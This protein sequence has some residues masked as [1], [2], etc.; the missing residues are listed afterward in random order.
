MNKNISELQIYLFKEGTN[1]ESYKMLG[2][3]LTREGCYFAVWAPNAR[4]VSV[5]GDFN[6]WNDQIHSMDNSESSGIWE[7]FIEGVREGAVYK[8]CIEASNGDKVLKSDPFG[9]SAETRP[10]N[11]S[12]VA[13]IDGYEW[14]DSQWEGC[15]LKESPQCK[16]MSIYEVNLGSWR[17]KEDG[18][19]LSYCELADELIAYVKDMKYTHIEIM[20]IS[21]YPFDGSWGYQVTGYFGVTSRYGSP[22][23]FMYMVDCC[24]QNNIGVILD[25]VPAHFPKDAHGLARFDG[26]CLYEHEDPRRG[27]HQDWGTYVFNF[28]RNEVRSFLISSAMF[29]ADCCH[30]DGIRVDAVSS[31]LYLDYSRKAGEWVPNKYGGRENLDAI[32]FLQKLNTIMEERH[33]NMLMIAEE[34]TSWAG[35]S[36]PVSEG[37]LGFTNKWNMGWMHDTLQY[38]SQESIHR[39]YHHDTITFSMVYAF[40]ERFILPLSHDEVVHGKKSLIERMP[41]DYWQKFANL[42]TL[43]GYMMA[44]PGKKLL[45]MGGEFGQFIEWNY[46]QG[47]DWNLLGYEMHSKLQEYVRTLNRFYLQEKALWER[48]FDTSGFRWIAADDR[49]Q[50]IIVFERLGSISEDS[51]IAVCNFT[52]VV[53]ENYRIGVPM[54]GE[55]YE[56]FNSDLESFGGSGQRNENPIKSEGISWHGSS[57]SISLKL[58]PLGVVYIKR[59]QNLLK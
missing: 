20:P 23:E 43:Y 10:N 48:D 25:W 32:E 13:C 1:Y 35:V 40:S 37:G 44:H 22:K 31:M 7:T 58:P 28:G 16:P 5:V 46:N 17:R 57:C 27:E 3:H 29:Y 52:P 6:G 24:H 45:F 26:T 4:N 50:S 19:F 47:L 12:R 18:S 8:Y 56:A 9:F 51:I 41:G 34:S 30:V 59:K 15:K 21:E 33:P 49:D 36:K 42:R 54:A 55:Y 39:K 14:G 38:M 2:S 53:R 11:A